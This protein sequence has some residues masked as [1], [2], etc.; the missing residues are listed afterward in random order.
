M[1]LFKMLLYCDVAQKAG[2]HFVRVGNA[3]SVH[4]DIQRYCL[5]ELAK[6]RFEKCMLY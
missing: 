2:I 6:G 3:S 5:S 4:S 1:I